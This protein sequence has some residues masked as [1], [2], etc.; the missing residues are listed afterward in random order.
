VLENV[1]AE[2]GRRVRLRLRSQREAP[3]LSLWFPPGVSYRGLTVNGVAPP[4]ADDSAAA[5]KASG[6][7]PVDSWRQVAILAGPVEGSLVAFQ[8][9]GNETVELLLADR[10]RVLPTGATGVASRRPER[11]VPSGQ[12]DGWV[13]WSRTAI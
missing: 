7:K 5:A 12:G 10:T 2:G 11:A 9:Q 6:P 8:L 3:I 13:V 4:G 1:P